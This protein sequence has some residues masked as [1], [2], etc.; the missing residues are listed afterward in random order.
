[1][2]HC[3]RNSPSEASSSPTCANGNH[4]GLLTQ[5]LSMIAVRPEPAQVPVNWAKKSFLPPPELPLATPSLTMQPTQLSSGLSACGCYSGYTSITARRVGCGLWMS[6]LDWRH[7]A[8]DS[9]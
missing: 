4:G 7:V 9:T 1:M 8:Q 3:T 5:Q 2:P 6:V